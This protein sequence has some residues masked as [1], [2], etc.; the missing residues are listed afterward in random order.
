MNIPFYQVDAFTDVPFKGNP[1]AICPLQTPLAD[2]L[3][4]KIA[5]ENN[6]SETAFLVPDDRG[7]YNLRWFTPTVEIDLCGHATLASAHILFTENLLDP[8]N[9]AV[10]HTKSGELTVK[11]KGD[12]LEM[13]FPRL[14][15]ERANLPADLFQALGVDPLETWSSKKFDLVEI[16]SAETLR[17]IAPD[18]NALKKHRP[19]IVTAKGDD[20]FD[21]YSRC[22]APGSGINE[23]PVTGSAHCVLAPY[24]APKLNKTSFTAFQSSARGGVIKVELANDKVL[25]AGN[26]VTVIRGTITA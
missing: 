26:A 6:L 16:A 15:P 10:F 19:T 4:Q 22:F 13:M 25:L 21:F 24:W 2:D 20:R 8:N 7:A 14:Q 17:T 3:M 12:W 18:F 9:T 1:A 23:D 11:K 5:L